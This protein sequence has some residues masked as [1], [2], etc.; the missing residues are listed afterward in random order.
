LGRLTER[1]RP[2]LA[3]AVSRDHRSAPLTAR[4]RAICAYAEK[5]TLTPWDMSEGDLGPMRAAGLSDREILDANLITCY[6]AYVN[7]LADGLGVG[8]EGGDDVLG[9]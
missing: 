3:D 8:L 7:R 1:E 4:E 9:W 2:G 6:F 5:L